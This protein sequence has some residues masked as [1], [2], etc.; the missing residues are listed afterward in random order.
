[1]SLLNRGFNLG[2][3]ADGGVDGLYT[4]SFGGTSAATPI[5][6]GVAAVVLSQQPG[7]RVDE[8]KDLLKRTATR[9][10]AV[11]SNGHS[12]LFG[13]GRVNLFAALK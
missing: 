11:D 9:M 4:N 6:A 12:D 1:V 13:F 8:L 3:C 10:G 2:A 5:A 7:L